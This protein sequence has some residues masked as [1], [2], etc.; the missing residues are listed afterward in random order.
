M[1]NPVLGALPNPY[2]IPAI[3]QIA[4]ITNAFPALVTTTFANNYLTGAIV[5]LYIPPY[6]GMK[7]ANYL[8]GAIIVTSPTTFTIDIDTTAFD[9]FVAPSSDTVTPAQ[10]VPVG[11]ETEHLDSAFRNILM[12]LF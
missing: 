1:A 11:E 7:Q 6:C 4:S 5:R 10:V 9:T 12:P 3:S 8:K 2:Q